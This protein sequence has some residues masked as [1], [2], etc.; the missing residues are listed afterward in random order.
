MCACHNKL[1]QSYN[2][3]DQNANIESTDEKGNTPLA[4]ACSNGNKP[5]V[6]FLVSIHANI[7][8]HPMRY[9]SDYVVTQMILLSHI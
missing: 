8:K 1:L 6:E 2:L 4:K 9:C 7:C 5:L 3:L